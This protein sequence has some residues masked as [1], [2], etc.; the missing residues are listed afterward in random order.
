VG[1]WSLFMLYKLILSASDAVES[2]T[3]IKS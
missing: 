2:G 3:S 1:L